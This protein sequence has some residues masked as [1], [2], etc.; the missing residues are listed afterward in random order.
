MNVVNLGT[1]LV[2]VTCVL[3]VLRVLAVEG[4]VVGGTLIVLDTA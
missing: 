3:L 2:N 1:L 4:V